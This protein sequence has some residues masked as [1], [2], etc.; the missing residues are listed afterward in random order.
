M[1]PDS[2][3]AAAAR[4]SHHCPLGLTAELWQAQRRPHHHGQRPAQRQR[5]TAQ[6]EDAGAPAA[7]HHEAAELQ[8]GEGGKAELLGGSRGVVRQAD[9]DS[10]CTAVQSLL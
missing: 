4:G 2:A 8:Q 10:R 9:S 1:P 5:A 6:V 7:R 3:L